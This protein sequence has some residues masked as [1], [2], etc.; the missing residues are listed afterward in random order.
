MRIKRIAVMVAATLASLT[1]SATAAVA[2]DPP[3]PRPGPGL[4]IAPWGAARFQ[5]GEKLYNE[6]RRT[7]SKLSGLAPVSVPDGRTLTMKVGMQQNNINFGLQIFYPGGWSITN[8][9]RGTRFDV[10][11]FWLN[12][13]QGGTNGKV[14]I[15]G[16]PADGNYKLASFTSTDV[17]ALLRPKILGY[18]IDRFPMKLTDKWAK[19]LNRLF[20]TE[21][22]AGDPFGELT[23]DLKFVP[24][25]T[26]A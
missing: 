24:T 8:A 12:I 22:A 25:R 26:A 17:L 21:L 4:Y 10:D 19:D 5:F 13:L 18:K 20:G 14:K 3:P 9:E 1:L 11:P 15:N 23:V 2:A 6:L 16:E 7:G